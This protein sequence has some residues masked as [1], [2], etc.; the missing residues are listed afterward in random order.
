MTGE[1]ISDENAGAALRL[2]VLTRMRD[3]PEL[4]FTGFM[5]AVT[6]LFS[7]LLDLTFNLPSGERAAFVGVHYLYPLLGLGLWAALAAVGQRRRVGSIF[8]IALPCY[9]IVLLC[10]FNLKLWSPHINPALWDDFFWMT[11][12]AVRPLVDASYAFREAIAPFLPYDSN[13]YMIAFIA[14]FYMSFCYHAIKAPHT[15]RT[16]FLAALFLQG[17]GALAYLVMPALGP[18]LYETGLETLPTSA[19]SSMHAAWEANV[20]GGK[21]WLAANGSQYLT[22]GLAAMPSLHAG[23]SF[24]FVYF[25]W[26]YGRILLVPYVPLF[27][28]LNV[29][30]IASRWHY[31]I[32]LP[33]GI[34]LAAFCCWLAQKLAPVP[35]ENEAD[36]IAEMGEAATKPALA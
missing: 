16:L 13:A 23:G 25:A 31:V 20:A 32:D 12:E 11:D 33:V 24:L 22:V 29:T 15:F 4:F 14:M 3:Y 19:Q 5:I 27:I 34:A 17:L 18:F 1:Q 6:A 8:L 9:A 26:R 10:H 28:Y 7:V 36:C 2:S 21:D 35:R 30:A